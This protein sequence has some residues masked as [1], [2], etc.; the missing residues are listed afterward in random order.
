MNYNQFLEKIF[1]GFNII[2]NFVSSTLETLMNNNFFKTIIYIVIFY[3]LITVIS[4]VIDLIFNITKIKK[5]KKDNK[6]IE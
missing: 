5:N 1:G 6:E 3:F 2:L 4:K